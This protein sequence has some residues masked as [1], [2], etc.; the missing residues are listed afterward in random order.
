MREREREIEEENTEREKT[1]ETE[2]NVSNPFVRELRAV[3]DWG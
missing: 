3:G 1:T 2:C